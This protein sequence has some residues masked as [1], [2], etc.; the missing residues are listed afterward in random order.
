[1]GPVAVPGGEERQYRRRSVLLMNGRSRSSEHLD[2]LNGRDKME[3]LTW[4]VPP[5]LPGEALAVA[6]LLK[7]PTPSYFLVQK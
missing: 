4:T 6:G 1:M 5:R 2:G 3:F 7:R